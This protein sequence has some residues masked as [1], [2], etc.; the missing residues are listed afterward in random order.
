MTTKKGDFALIRHFQIDYDLYSKSG[1]YETMIMMLWNLLTKLCNDWSMGAV[2]QNWLLRPACEY[3]WARQGP[4]P[5]GSSQV[6]G[7]VVPAL[8]HSV[9]LSCAKG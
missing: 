8:G 1:F 4:G 6:R 5:D 7:Q 2:F 3:Q 9:L